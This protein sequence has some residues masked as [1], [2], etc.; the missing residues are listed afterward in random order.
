MKSNF[1]I[2]EEQKLY[3]AS[4]VRKMLGFSIYLWEKEKR[5]IPCINVGSEKRG[6]LYFNG[7]DLNMY[8]RM[9]VS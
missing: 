7:K 6:Y 8:L 5:N 9:R 4:E 1:D 3:K 2:F